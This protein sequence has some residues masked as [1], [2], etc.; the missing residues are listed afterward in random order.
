MLSNGT[1]LWYIVDKQVWDGHLQNGPKISVGTGTITRNLY[2]DYRE[3]VKVTPGVP[4]IEGILLE[5]K[6]CCTSA[7]ATFDEISIH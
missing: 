1:N 5:I 3:F 7:Y 4:D 2:S 6:V